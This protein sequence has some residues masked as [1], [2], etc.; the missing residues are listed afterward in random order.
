MCTYVYIHTHTNDFILIG[1]P[2]CLDLTELNPA[3][4][5][6]YIYT[7][8]EDKTSAMLQQDN[9]SYLRIFGNDNLNGFAKF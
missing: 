3:I 4:L 8:I 2:V 7:Y 5:C 1:R 9:I 6:I